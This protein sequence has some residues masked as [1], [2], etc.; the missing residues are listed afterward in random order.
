M[1]AFLALPSYCQHLPKQKIAIGTGAFAPLLKLTVLRKLRLGTLQVIDQ[2][3]VTADPKIPR[4]AVSREE[5][6]D[7]GRTALD[8]AILESQRQFYGNT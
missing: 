3:N 4:I 6:T 7:V 2:D 1:R 5:L 8:R